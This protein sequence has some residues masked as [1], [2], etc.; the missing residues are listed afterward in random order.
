[1]TGPLDDMNLSVRGREAI[2]EREGVILRAY[3]DTE[4]VWT[5]GAGHTHY[6]GAPIPRAGM[7]ITRQQSDDMFAKDIVRYEKIVKTNVRVP[8]LQNEYDALVSICYNV[9]AAL[10]PK[11][12][13]VRCL[14]EGDKEGSEHA[15]MLYIRPPEIIGR[16]KTELKQFQTPY[17]EA[18]TGATGITIAMADN[19][20]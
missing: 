17:P 16:R 5:I 7:V 20:S 9:E 15:I 4:G 3:R 6:D 14:N 19:R 8:L 10:G 2:E 13:I 11:S 1:M 18:P 12:S